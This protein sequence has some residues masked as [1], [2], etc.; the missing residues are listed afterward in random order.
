M[1]YPKPQI[2]RCPMPLFRAGYVIIRHVCKRSKNE[3][4]KG[5]N[6]TENI[7]TTN[8]FTALSD[9]LGKTES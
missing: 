1:T 4:S 8:N 2:L 7:I 5:D 9:G 3:K 6:F